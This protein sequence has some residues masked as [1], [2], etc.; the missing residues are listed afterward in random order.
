MADR[1]AS[2]LVA[3]HEGDRNL[4][5]NRLLATLTVKER[6]RL[7]P[8]LKRVPLSLGD[9]LYDSD[10]RI[11]YVYFPTSGVG[12]LLCAIDDGA[13]TEVGTV[14]ME[15]MAGLSVFLGVDASPNRALGQAAGEA[16]RTKGKEFREVGRQNGGC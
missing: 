2:Y 1:K 7:L 15:G 12:S 6:E 5:E 16:L 14:G 8:N 13:S 3:A 4:S 11:R 10:E 9:V